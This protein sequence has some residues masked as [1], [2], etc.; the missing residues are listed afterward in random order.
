MSISVSGKLIVERSQEPFGLTFILRNEG[1]EPVRVL[2]WYSL[3]E[4]L[5]SNCLDV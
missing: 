4:G 1:N 5:Q 3:L 2:K